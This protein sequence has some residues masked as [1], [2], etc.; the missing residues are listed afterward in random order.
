MLR[1]VAGR[2]VSSI[3]TLLFVGLAL[4]ALTR[5]GPGSP[6]R[7]VLGADATAEQIAQFE[8]A[9]GLDRPFLSQYAAWLGDILRGDFGRSF[10]TGRDV[11]TDIVNALPVTL[12]I[13]LFAFAIALVCGVGIGVLAA[14]RPGG[15]FDRVSRFAAVLGLSIP[16]FW[17]GIVLIRFLAVDLRWLP[18]GGY[19]PLSAGLKLHLQSILMPSL[20]L[21]VYY[22]AVLARMTQASLQ[23]TLRGDYVRTARAMG[24]SSRQVVFYALVNALPPVVNLAALSFGYMFG[25]ALIIEQVFNIP[26]LSRALLNAISQRDFLLLQGIVFLFTAIFVF[27]NLGADLINR[28]LDPR[29]RAAA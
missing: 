21:A 14:L 9:H 2:I 25:W 29:Q 16:A 28:V 15:T 23:E 7:I 8:Q 18:P 26:G 22:I 17:L 20:S 11:A 1:L 10:V 5:S 13:V 24:L 19:F 27:A 3:G 12:S 4:F 6:A